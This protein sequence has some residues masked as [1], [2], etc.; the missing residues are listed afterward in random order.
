IGDSVNIAARLESCEKDCQPSD[1][2]ILIAHETLV[3]LQEEFQVEAWGA[4]QLKGKQQK[5]DVYRVIGRTALEGV[6]TLP[7]RLISRSSV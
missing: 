4:L 7:S 2:R 1:C 6:G 5:V 3:H